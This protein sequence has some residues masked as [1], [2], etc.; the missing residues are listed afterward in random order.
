MAGGHSA[1]AVV[2]LNQLVQ[3]DGKDPE[4]FL[5]GSSLLMDRR[6]LK[7]EGK[8]YLVLLLQSFNRS[9]DYAA[10]AAIL[11]SEDGHA[12][13]RV[14]VATDGHSASFSVGFL[15]QAS[16]D[17]PQIAFDWKVVRSPEVFKTCRVEQWQ[18]AAR[19]LV[20]GKPHSPMLQLA[21]RG[22]RFEIR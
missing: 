8:V 9:S 3:D 10:R 6:F 17:G 4:T 7:A 2:Q 1:L 20:G 14:V 19:E 13:D 22:D 18:R 15:E 5:A 21:I 12:L 16:A 11:L